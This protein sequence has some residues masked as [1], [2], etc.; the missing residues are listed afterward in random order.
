MLIFPNNNI[1]LI[2]NKQMIEKLYDML[3]E[4]GIEIIEDSNEDMDDLEQIAEQVL[5]AIG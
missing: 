3:E 5:S 2:L 1:H 4:Q